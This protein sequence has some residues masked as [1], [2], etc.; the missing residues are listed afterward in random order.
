MIAYIQPLGIEGPILTSVN[1]ANNFC[2]NR[3]KTSK[4]NSVQ[5]RPVKNLLRESLYVLEMKACFNP[6]VD[7]K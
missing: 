5:T 4:V 6:E 7:R 1:E 2:Y 3:R